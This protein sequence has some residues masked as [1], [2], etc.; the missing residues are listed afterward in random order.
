MAK[1][2]FA[3]LAALSRLTFPSCLKRR[4]RFA[5]SICFLFSCRN[6]LKRLFNLLFNFLA[7]AIRAL[8]LRLR[9]AFLLLALIRCLLLLCRLFLDRPAVPAMSNEKYHQGRNKKELGNNSDQDIT[10][11]DVQLTSL[12]SR[13]PG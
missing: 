8:F 6:V 3:F 12:I 11:R 5:V 2:S 9:L 13:H 4:A 7:L 1:A 10:K